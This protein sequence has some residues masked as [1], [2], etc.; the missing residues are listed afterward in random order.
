MTEKEIR[1]F[2][3][4]GARVQFGRCI[5]T[6]PELIPEFRAALNTHQHPDPAPPE[7]P[8]RFMSQAARQAIGRRMR[9]YWKAKRAAKKGR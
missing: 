7:K 9:A 1:E 3:I 8:K 5:E 4:E 2:A 6:F